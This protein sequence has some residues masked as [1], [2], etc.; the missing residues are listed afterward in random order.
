MRLSLTH[1]P[2]GSGSAS[3]NATRD[4]F[5]HFEIRVSMNLEVIERTTYCA[6][7]CRAAADLNSNH[8]AASFFRISLPVSK[9]SSLQKCTFR[10]EFTCNYFSFFLLKKK[11]RMPYL[12]I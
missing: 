11:Q 1:H 4:S 12:E 6:T 10:V 9:D 8:G 5:D 2:W 3:C 7:R